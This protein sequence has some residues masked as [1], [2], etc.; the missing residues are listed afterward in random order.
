MFEPVRE[1]HRRF[2]K[3]TM[4]GLPR[5]AHLTRYSMY[6]RLGEV[7]KLLPPQPEHALCISHSTHL[8]DLMG[9]KPANVTEANYPEYKMN[10]LP[11]ADASFD[12]VTSDQVLEHV[13]GDPVEAVEQTRRVLKPGGIAVHTTV[14]NYP[15]HG[16]P[17]DFWRYT[18]DALRF[19]CRNFSEI[20][21][22]SGWGSF[23]A[24]KWARRGMQFEP[25]PHAAWH[26]LHKVATRNE[27][28]W[29]IV[30]WVVARR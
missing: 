27:A 6:K 21:E 22:C 4:I 20:I 12:L 18:P 2:W 16:V 24:W 30:T 29:P 13:E 19:L 5:G 28:E 26:P 17:G 9:L 23:K 7:G 25:V 11:F 3:A 15:I 10:E 14:F 8:L 1:I